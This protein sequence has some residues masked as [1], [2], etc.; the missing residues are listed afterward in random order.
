MILS[1]CEITPYPKFPRAI[2]SKFM[3]RMELKKIKTFTCIRQSIW[4]TPPPFF[5]S[6]P[7][8][9]VDWPRLRLNCSLILRLHQSLTRDWSVTYLCLIFHLIMPRPGIIHHF[10]T[11]G[12]N[13]LEYNIS[14][15]HKFTTGNINWK[16]LTKFSNVSVT[17]QR[18]SKPMAVR[19]MLSSW[20]CK[21]NLP[22]TSTQICR[23]WP[24]I[25]GR[26]SVTTNCRLWKAIRIRFSLQYISIH[27]NLH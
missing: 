8:L 25:I 11:I 2:P 6:S 27:H 21:P 10:L 3:G 4:W 7:W 16:N 26:K 19:L 5:F 15:I 9:Y 24:G 12:N 20:F 13:F 23:H 17:E 14:N 22:A 18:T 1:E